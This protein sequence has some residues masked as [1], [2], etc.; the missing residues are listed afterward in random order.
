MNLFT[1]SLDDVNKFDMQLQN[2]EY[3]S[4]N[5]TYLIYNGEHN[6]DRDYN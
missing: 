6:T 1:F 5:Y 4:N 3:V 2:R